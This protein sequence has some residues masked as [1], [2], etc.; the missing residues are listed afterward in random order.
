M[1]Y[2]KADIGRVIRTDLETNKE[3]ALEIYQNFIDDIFRLE[4]NGT[5]YLFE[6]DDDYLVDCFDGYTKIDL[7][8]CLVRVFYLDEETNTWVEDTY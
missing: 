3:K 2:I 6:I 4:E 7:D 8:D 1:F 5:I